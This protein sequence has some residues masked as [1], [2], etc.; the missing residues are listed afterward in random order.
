[1]SRRDFVTI[2][3]TVNRAAFRRLVR[4]ATLNG[5]AEQDIAG[6]FLDFGFSYVD[7]MNAKTRMEAYPY[8]TGRLGREER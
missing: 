7:L 2:P 4:F 8:L 3:V 5:M 6:L 1:M